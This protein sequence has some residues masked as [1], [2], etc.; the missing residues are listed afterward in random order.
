[1]T[2]KAE[3]PSEA[4]VREWRGEWSRM[5][6]NL[7]PCDE[8]N[9][10][11]RKAIEWALQGAVP[12]ACKCSSLD[13]ATDAEYMPVCPHCKGIKLKLLKEA[14]LA[15]RIPPTQYIKTTSNDKTPAPELPREALRKLWDAGDLGYEIVT[16]DQMLAAARVIEKL[17]SESK[18]CAGKDV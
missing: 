7:R 2:N 10:V 1:M 5:S 8:C 6:G 9:Y 4:Q 11:A 16:F 3:Y 13:Y 18:G 15:M 14:W 12:V 17:L